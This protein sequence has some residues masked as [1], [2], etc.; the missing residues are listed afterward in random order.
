LPHFPI[1]SAP[2]SCRGASRA[3]GEVSPDTRLLPC[4]SSAGESWGHAAPLIPYASSVGR[5]PCDTLHHRG[6]IR[7]SATQGV[8]ERRSSTAPRRGEKEQ[9]RGGEKVQCRDP[10]ERRKPRA[11]DFPC[12]SASSFGPREIRPLSDRGTGVPSSCGPH[13]PL[14][15]TW[16][17]KAV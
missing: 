2:R 14:P 7:T 17:W 12:S 15:T 11:P 10:P 5:G 13:L 16:L 3:A 8:Q 6:E 4:S 9:R 1:S